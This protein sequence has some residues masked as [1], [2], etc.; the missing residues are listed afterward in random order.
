MLGIT[1]GFFR[2][3]RNP[4]KIFPKGL[5]PVS[6][7]KTGVDMI[8][9]MNNFGYDVEDNLQTSLGYRSLSDLDDLI[10]RLE[11]ENEKVDWERRKNAPTD[12]IKPRGDDSVLNATYVVDRVTVANAT[13]ESAENDGGA[14]ENVSVGADSYSNTTVVQTRTKR[15][16]SE[17]GDFAPTGQDDPRALA[18]RVL[19]M[20]PRLKGPDGK[21]LI[22][23]L[24]EEQRRSL[25]GDGEDGEISQMMKQFLAENEMMLKEVL[26]KEDLHNIFG[27]NGAFSV[28]DI[29]PM[30]SLY[31]DD[32][33][34][35]IKGHGKK[36]SGTKR[37]KYPGPTMKQNKRKKPNNAMRRPTIPSRMK[38]KKKN[39]STTPISDMMK[40]QLKNKVNGNNKGEDTRNQTRGG[41]AEFEEYE[42]EDEDYE[43][44]SGDEEKPSDRDESDSREEVT[45]ERNGGV[46]HGPEVWGHAS[47]QQSSLLR[48]QLLPEMATIPSL[49]DPAWIQHMESVANSYRP[50]P[51]SYLR[52]IPYVGPMI[53]SMLGE[54]KKETNPPGPQYQA[55]PVPTVHGQ[56]ESYATEAYAQET[57]TEYAPSGPASYFSAVS[58]NSATIG[59]ALISALALGG[60]LVGI[61]SGSPLVGLGLL[62]RTDPV[63][64]SRRDRVPSRKPPPGSFRRPLSDYHT[65]YVLYILESRQMKSLLVLLFLIVLLSLQRGAWTTSETTFLSNSKTLSD[66]PSW[67]TPRSLSSHHRAIS[68]SI[69]PHTPGVPKTKPSPGQQRHCQQR[70]CQMLWTTPA[71]PTTPT[72][73]ETTTTTASTTTRTT[74]SP[75]NTLVTRATSPRSGWLAKASG[76]LMSLATG[77]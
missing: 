68:E 19:E 10:N 25:R 9:T 60:A 66:Q 35:A 36:K 72:L 23:T 67:T 61:G 44:A 18:A 17:D 49:F 40:G 20:L 59:S 21:K 8:R 62:A 2:F 41:P 71:L 74:T 55:Q 50:D 65:R 11:K 31:H 63:R 39:Q 53:E 32:E 42:Y 27:N 70:L 4:L 48:P 7:L 37:R 22:D 16:L 45:T 26:Q 15:A 43:E 28:D 33:S 58:G 3:F 46:T 73:S 24:S 64:E 47:D 76:P 30:S 69:F 1:C 75:Q 51:G 14:K 56:Q 52:Y 5:D 54:E 77:Q 13:V 38:Q 57:A 6:V 12:S 29:I 34:S